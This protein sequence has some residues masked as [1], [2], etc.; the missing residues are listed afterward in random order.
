MKTPLNKLSFDFEYTGCIYTEEDIIAREFP[1]LSEEELLKRI[2]NSTIY[3]DYPNRFKFVTDIYE[4]GKVEGVNNVGTY[5]VGEWSIRDNIFELQ[6]QNSW[7]N[8]H[9]HAYL[10]KDSIMF[11][12]TSTGAWRTTFKFFIPWEN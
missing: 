2:V 1:L 10:V 4:N 8:T 7:Q 3:G 11:F 5:D 6:W 9:T 12:D